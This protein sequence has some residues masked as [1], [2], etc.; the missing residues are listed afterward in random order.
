MSDSTVL[1]SDFEI[2]IPESVRSQN[3]WD[4][5]QEFA[6]VPTPA[7]VLLVPVPTRDRLQGIAAG[8]NTENYRDRNDRY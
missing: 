2:Q 5:G 4:V 8:A 3:K 7:E 6:F 1:S